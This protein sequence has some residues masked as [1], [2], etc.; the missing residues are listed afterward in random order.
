MG[1]NLGNRVQNLFSALAK[2][3]SRGIHLLAISKLYESPP[4]GFKSSNFFLNLVA[5]IRT[6]L[7]P[8]ALLFEAKKVEWELGR[9]PTSK[10]SNYTD[11]PIDID[12]IF[13]EDLILKTKTLEIPHP[14]AKDRGFVLFPLLE[15][16]PNMVYPGL[17]KTI[18]EILAEKKKIMQRQRVKCFS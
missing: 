14:K 5:K 18:K 12:I 15:L 10:T 13:Y 3:Q 16:D 17:K 1:S 2:L 9:K 4:L 6:S 8:Q 11:R 7:S